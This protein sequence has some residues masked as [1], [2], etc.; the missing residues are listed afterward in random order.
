MSFDRRL[1]EELRR[2]AARIEAEVER[3]LGAVEARARRRG[4]IPSIGLLAAAAVI[5]LAILLRVG[6][7]RPD[8]GSGAATPA[9]PSHST[10][11]SPSGPANY[12]Q[13]AGTYTVTLDPTDPAVEHD[14]LG[15]LWTMRLQPDGLVL[16]SP[17]STFAP[18]PGGLTGIAF[19]LDGDRFRTNLFYNDHCGSAGT[20]TWSRGAGR[21]SLTPVGDTCSIRRTLLSTSSWATSP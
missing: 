7:P 1:R 11:P 2:D 10:V 13:I 18:G 15:G 16:L 3:N 21:L 12:P 19:S 20:Y 9:A 6:E 17:P 8:S 5:A 4:D 14:G